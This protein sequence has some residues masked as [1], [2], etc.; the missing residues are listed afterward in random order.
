VKPGTLLELVCRAPS[1]FVSRAEEPGETFDYD[2]P[3]GTRGLVVG[4]DEDGDA[5]IAI[6]PNM[7]RT[8]WGNCLKNY[9]RVV[10]EPK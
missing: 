6:F 3:T 8:L 5:V 1:S 4:V 9:W 10:E 7:E 2:F